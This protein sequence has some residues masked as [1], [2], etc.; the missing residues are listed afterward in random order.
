MHYD[1]LETFKTTASIVSPGADGG[2]AEFWISSEGESI[3]S[4]GRLLAGLYSQKTA[5]L[6]EEWEVFHATVSEEKKT[7]SYERPWRITWS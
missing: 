5:I 7:D 1:Q 3:Y 2:A 6:L 4:P